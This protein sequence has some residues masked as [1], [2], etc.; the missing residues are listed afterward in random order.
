MERRNFKKFENSI[1]ELIKTKPGQE[2]NMYP[3]IKK[4]FE[5][6]G[7]PS[8]QVKT[9]ISIL[10]SHF[11]PDVFITIPGKAVEH[12]WVVVEAKSEKGLFLNQESATRI[13]QEKQKY[14]SVETEWFVLIDPECW[15]IIP[16]KAFIPELKNAKTFVL[17]D[18]ANLLCQYLV[19]NLSPAAYERKESIQKFIE[20]DITH[21]ASINISTS[22]DDFFLTLEKSFRLLFTETE[23]LFNNYAVNYWE[24]IQQSL[25]WLEQQFSVRDIVSFDP[26]FSLCVE[27]FQ[28]RSVD[29]EKIESEY[30]KLRR[31]YV[32]SPAAFRLFYNFLWLQKQNISNKF[33]S[34]VVFN[35]A[36][37]LLSKMLTIRFL[38]DYSFFGKKFFSNGGIKAFNEVRSHFELQYSELIRHST[39]A[40]RNIFPIIMEDTPY[41]WILDFSDD[42][43]SE[44][45]ETILYWLS[46]FNFSTISED[47][48]SQIYTKMVSPAM[49]KKLGQVFTPSW[50]VDYIVDRVISM[51]GSSATVLDPACGSGTFLV[52]WFNKTA[53]QALKR[54]VISFE[55]ASEIIS[56]IHGNDIDPLAA[57]L[58]KLQL[59][60]CLLN[61]SQHLKEKGLPELKV[62]TGNAIALHDRIFEKQGLWVI[63]DLRTYDAVVGNPPYVRPE[64]MK[65]ETTANERDFF[66]ELAGANLRSKFLFKA[67]KSWL[68]ENGV[69]GFVLSLSVLDSN[70]ENFLRR[71]FTTK[72]TIKE[73]VDLELASEIVFPDVSVNP[74]VLIV[75]KRPPKPDDKVVLKFLDKASITVNYRPKDILN[76]LTVAKIPYFDVFV[77]TD[78]SIRILSKVTPERLRV[79]KKIASYPCF[80]DIT[81]KWWRR[82]KK[83]RFVEASLKEKREKGWDESLMV[84]MGL[85]FRRQKK[86]GKWSV[87]K[88]ENIVACYMI[89]SPAESNID[90]TEASDPSFWRFADLLP[91]KAYAFRR[92]CTAPTACL[93][94]PTR[95]A[96]TNTATIFFPDKDVEDFPF[97]FLILAS[98][99]RFYYTFWLREGV[100]AQL[101]SD[102]YPRTVKN[103]PWSEKL[104]DY[105]EELCKLKQQ[106]LQACRY[107]NSELPELI[108]EKVK[109]DSIENI[110]L[111][112]EDIQFRFSKTHQTIK[113]GWYT[114]NFSLFDWV[115]VNNETM[116][117][118]LLDAIRLYGVSSVDPEQILKLK[119]PANETALEM[120]NAILHGDKIKQME[121][122][123]LLT[124]KKLNQ[125]VY[126]AFVLTDEDVEVIEKCGTDSLMAYL[127]PAEPFTEKQLRGFWSGLDLAE[128]YIY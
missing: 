53:G 36:L 102:V 96:F 17:P 10:G 123:K 81:R 29:W 23:R 103:F 106:Y 79:L 73:I 12:I 91:E 39:R 62:S 125:I 128:R 67:L 14:L 100:V 72:Y 43:F 44:A 83:N 52:S 94:N 33:S 35:S 7:W 28:S 111:Q 6:I 80:A 122:L 9:D 2:R 121:N 25:T 120:W 60:W 90:V 22:Q 59:T 117:R 8:K 38:E 19:E 126:R 66:K 87:Y 93:F 88:G 89:D 27:M 110:A 47:I 71:A 20:G 3:Y 54:Q 24:E 51:V 4:I 42:L 85:A 16:V 105:T 107:T 70:Q 119:V 63:F 86:K 49:R 82:K 48:L 101:W 116:H 99:Y 115:Q 84:G 104:K 31:L 118:V 112:R 74:I 108:R 75:E 113:S 92:I 46:F 57:S 58:T 32:R 77:K 18:Q 13:V 65:I 78:D 69:V 109:L 64:I 50:L 76:H 127:K 40:A 68:R 45:V 61:F 21:V 26:Q 98:V 41:D 97:D 11:R 56:K 15:K 5:H 37:L 55:K 30:E 114:I 124:L 34:T 1:N 95:Q